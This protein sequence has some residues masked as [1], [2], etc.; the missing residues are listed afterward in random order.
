MSRSTSAR[1]MERMV[2]AMLRQHGCAVLRTDYGKHRKTRLRLPSG[3]TRLL[4]T[5]TSP[6]SA[7]E[8]VD[9]ARRNVVA[10]IIEAENRARA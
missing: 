8:T 2:N 7:E 6:R 10:M 1:Y 4:V 9:N 5:T 3:D